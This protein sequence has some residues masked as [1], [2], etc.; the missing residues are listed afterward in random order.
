MILDR[1]EAKNFGRYR[2]LTLSSLPE[3]GLI[4][5][6]GPNESG[7]TTIGDIIC[8]A[9]FGRTSADKVPEEHIHWREDEMNLQIDFR[10]AENIPWRIEREI[11]RSGT[12]SATLQRLDEQKAEAIR[13]VGKVQ[14]QVEKVLR[15]DF[16]E[17]TY[18]F[19]LG[20]KELDVSKQLAI[21]TKRHLV[22]ELTGV[23]TIERAVDQVSE[24][25]DGLIGERVSL[26]EELRLSSCLL[27]EY[28][29]RRK[30]EEDPTLEIDELEK[31]EKELAN[32]VE[33]HEQTLAHA[34]AYDRYSA[35]LR[36]YLHSLKAKAYSYVLAK[37][38]LWL[39]I[40]EKKLG[41]QL[42][43]READLS[44]LD[45]TGKRREQFKAK[46]KELASVVAMRHNQ[47]KRALENKLPAEITP[48]DE[49]IITPDGKIEQLVITRLRSN[50]AAEA[51]QKLDSERNRFF[52]G[53]IIAAGLTYLCYAMPDKTLYKVVTT[54]G[55][56]WVLF[57]LSAIFF[58]YGGLFATRANAQHEKVE[59][60]K[61]TSS[62]LERDVSK[63]RE[64]TRLC[65][66]FNVD[67]LDDLQERLEK[68]GGGV[69][70]EYHRELKE[71]YEEFL[72]GR[73]DYLRSERGAEKLSEQISELHDCLVEVRH[74]QVDLE[75]WL[76]RFSNNPFFKL[77]SVDGQ[78]DENIVFERSS[79]QQS[80]KQLNREVEG[81]QKA[82][83]ILE[84][85]C[86]SPV[87]SRICSSFRDFQ[88]TVE[89]LAKLVKREHKLQLG[90]LQTVQKGDLDKFEDPV[91]FVFKQEQRL[92]AFC[93]SEDDGMDTADEARTKLA[94]SRQDLGQLRLKLAEAQQRLARLEPDALRC[95]QLEDEIAKKKERHTE[96]FRAIRVREILLEL[97]TG[98]SERMREKL[99]PAIADYIRCVL[100][101]ITGFRYREVQLTED[102]DIQVYSPEKGDYVHLEELSGGTV[103]QLLVSMRLAFA[104]ALMD[105]KMPHEPH[106][107]LFFD[108][109]LSSFD[110]GRAEAFLNLLRTFG[111]TFAQVFLVSHLGGLK[112]LFDAV[113]LTHLDKDELMVE[114]APEEAKEKE[115]SLPASPPEVETQ[116]Q[117]S[118]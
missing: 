52:I 17:F 74:V 60:L 1:L 25:L 20:Q 94:S 26:D 73:T 31:E 11:D 117:V 24:E 38:R 59:R 85:E 108:E 18:A 58:G 112:E 65:D 86:R 45:E 43:E 28:Q 87:S 98:L 21:D 78:I 35:K 79:F 16:E 7:K 118:P 41:K 49:D 96:V 32:V 99:A 40:I 70:S 72:E 22:D 88:E 67:R 33:T 6:V 8:F 82:L 30:D 81:C 103:D 12:Y 113:V 54:K 95:Q 97:L 71:E 15:L 93:P 13:G 61:E 104:K 110:K 83:F 23:G 46:L 105:A 4:G 76:S 14:A 36:N 62:K 115:A 107:F 101:P 116:E 5:V 92:G 102:L 10:D 53:F 47:I 9:L 39:H 55:L 63:L 90:Q 19:F 64:A 48:G 42:K 27:E 34:E 106:Q 56:Y 37:R 109:P 44:S 75:S 2:S 68:I 77:P 3:R 89:E 51:A 50:R 91:D 29:G 80:S 114:V 111:G 84:T 100:P 69:L 66:E 57:F